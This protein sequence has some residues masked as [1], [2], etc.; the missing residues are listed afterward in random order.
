MKI[1][2]TIIAIQLLTIMTT[3]AQSNETI[4]ISKGIVVKA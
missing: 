2:K 1:A 4:S 3:A